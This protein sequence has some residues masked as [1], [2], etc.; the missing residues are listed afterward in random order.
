MD[1]VRGVESGLPNRSAIRYT[2]ND[3]HADGIMYRFSA[4]E[5]SSGPGGFV[6]A[7]IVQLCSDVTVLAVAL[8]GLATWFALCLAGWSAVLVGVDRVRAWR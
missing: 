4:I 2:A 8:P 5:R 3:P 6:A 1:M 7:F